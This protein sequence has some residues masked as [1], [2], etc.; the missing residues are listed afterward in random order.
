MNE[1]QLYNS[2]WMMS[3]NILLWGKTSQKNKHI[4]NSSKKVKLNNILFSDIHISGKTIKK[5][6]EM[7]NQIQNQN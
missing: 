7:I 3:K 4:I 1:L 5:S 6:K 2:T